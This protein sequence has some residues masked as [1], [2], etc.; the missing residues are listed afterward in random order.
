MTIEELVA[1]LDKL[2]DNVVVGGRDFEADHHEADML[3]LK[4]I[5]DE[6]VNK[7]FSAVGRWYS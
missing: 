1:E 5:N 4:Y 2:K 3:L 6:N 7:A